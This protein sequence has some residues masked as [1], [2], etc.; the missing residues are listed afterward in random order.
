MNSFILDYPKKSENYV[1]ENHGEMATPLCFSFLRISSNFT[2]MSIFRSSEDP[3]MKTFLMLFTSVHAG[4]KSGDVNNS[5]VMRSIVFMIF[6]FCYFQSRKIFSGVI[7]S[8]IR[9]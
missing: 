4:E 5:S 1:T 2:D 7:Y 8:K 9:G 6:R 3:R